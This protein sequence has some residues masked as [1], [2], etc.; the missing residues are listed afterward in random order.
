MFKR[1][2]NLAYLLMLNL[3]Y[4]AVLGSIFYSVLGNLYSYDL[5]KIGVPEFC[6]TAMM[7]SVVVFFSIDFVY[8]SL[9][10]MYR[11]Y[12][13]IADCLILVVMQGAFD[14]INFL[15]NHYRPQ[16]FS[17]WMAVTFMIFAIWD[18]GKRKGM[19]QTFD[20]LWYTEAALAG[21]YFALGL[22]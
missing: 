2:A 6:C 17:G 9:H 22:L 20:R 12:E 11:I 14:S 8:T 21:G 18:Y 1:D 4:P 15:A 16:R 13:F 3:L 7:L 10:E 5:T 19:G